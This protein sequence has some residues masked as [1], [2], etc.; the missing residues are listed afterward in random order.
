VTAPK[1]HFAALAAI[2]AGVMA[3]RR[4]LQ[5]VTSR[6]RLAHHN[7]LPHASGDYRV[8]RSPDDP[9]GLLEGYLV[10]EL[11]PHDRNRFDA[12]AAM[13]D[14]RRLM[15]AALRSPHDRDAS[16]PGRD[17]VDVGAWWAECKEHMRAR[18]GEHAASA[19]ELPPIGKELRI[20][21]ALTSPVRWW[22]H[23]GPWIA[24]AAS[25]VCTSLGL[26]AL[27]LSHARS[28][29]ATKPVGEHAYTT[30]R[31]ERAVVTLDGATVVLGPESVL[32]ISG[33][34]GIA[35]RTISIQG[36][37]S[38]DVTPDS[39]HPF[40]VW[41]AGT[42]TQ[43][44]GTRFDLRAYPRD[45]GIR[46]VVAEGA[47]AMRMRRSALSPTAP[48]L[49]TRGMMATTGADG[50][51]RLR[52]G[53]AA[54]RYLAWSDGRLTFDDTPLSDAVDEIGRWYDLDIR[55]ADTRLAS[56]RL[57]ATFDDPPAAVLAALESALGIRAIQIGRV[58]TLYPP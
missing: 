28:A 25:I 16:T 5:I 52:S 53:I 43:D 1:P 24:I 2:R 9:G 31:G 26:W 30:A 19:V 58:V 6:L 34:Y 50:V 32:R 38:F 51:V 49:L 11:A 12:W 27:H 40:R 18:G 14:G 23:P 45:S 47:V 29:R 56:K 21:I 13:D 17:D 39:A 35:D 36:H 54:D 3:L 41:T 55:L 46:L 44:I 4:R 7:C 20:G 42:L 37:A 33:S 48:V 15:V 22:R 57:T 8:A 10:S